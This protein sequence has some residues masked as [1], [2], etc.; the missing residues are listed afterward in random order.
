MRIFQLASAS[1]SNGLLGTFGR[2]FIV[3]GSIVGSADRQEN[4][5][6]NASFCRTGQAI[7]IIIEFG[8]V[9]LQVAE[10]VVG[11]SVFAANLRNFTDAVAA[12]LVFHAIASAVES[13]LDLSAFHFAFVEIIASIDTTNRLEGESATAG[14]LTRSVA[15]EGGSGALHDCS[16]FISNIIISA[17]R[18]SRSIRRSLADNVGS[19]DV[20]H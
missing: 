6:A 11:F 17:N 8:I 12:F 19:C 1:V 14:S 16:A 2:T 3:I 10:I 15:L 18:C 13:L 4:L 5:G 7:A 20:V 9:A